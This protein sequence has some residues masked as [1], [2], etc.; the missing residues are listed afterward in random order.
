MVLPTEAALM[1]ETCGTLSEESS[2]TRDVVFPLPFKEEICSGWV[3]ENLPV[4]ETVME[5]LSPEENERGRGLQKQH[6]SS[7]LPDAV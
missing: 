5:R 2:D 4:Q 1:R 6:M 3:E 7:L